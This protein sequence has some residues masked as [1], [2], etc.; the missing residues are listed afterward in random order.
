MSDPAT[1][2]SG[3][4]EIFLGGSPEAEQKI[5]ADILPQV[6]EIQATVAKR[7]GAAIR[8]G[9]HNKGTPLRIAFEVAQDLPQ[10]LQV[11]FLKPR[12]RYEGFGR[13]SRSQSLFAADSAL[14]QRG[15]AFRLETEDG[16][17]DFLFSNTPVSYAEDPVT[18]LRGGLIFASSS[19]P[20]APFKL[21]WNFGIRKGI[22]ILKDVLGSPD[23]AIS[24]SSQRF[25]TRVAFQ[26]GPG[27]ASFTVIPVPDQRVMVTDDRPDYLTR[28]LGEELRAGERRFV[29]N[30]Q[31]FVSE[32]KTPIEN[33]NREWKEA[34]APLIPV[35]EVILLQQDLDSEES[36][37]L[38]NR[39][40]QSDAFNPWNTKHL[41]PLGAMNRARKE[42]YDRS[43]RA[44]G[45]SPLPRAQ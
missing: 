30:A 15:F 14:D 44:R 23:R 2:G 6:E 40:E 22:R 4:K 19:K 8:R 25:W 11:G 36:V 41:R 38:A 5:L 12:A 16:P 18:F 27:A 17:Q 34:D 43:A 33:T 28:H 37:A 9:F 35:G 29:L 32:D 13:F 24:F 21:F 20:A 42:G 26:I 3:W 10:H 31:M 7:Q 39:I 45:G 1:P